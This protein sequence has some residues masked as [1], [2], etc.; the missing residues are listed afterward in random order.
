MSTR[1]VDLIQLRID[2]FIAEQKT[3]LIA[4]APELAEVTDLAHDFLS[5]GKRFRGLFCYW[6][7][8]AV[9]GTVDHFHN[10]VGLSATSFGDV[11]VVDHR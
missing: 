7:W 4:I 10:E 8:N 11:V 2:D 5:G 3:G 1:L 6:G 9:A